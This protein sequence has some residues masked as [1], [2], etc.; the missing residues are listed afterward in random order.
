M[1]NASLLR[2]ILD[3]QLE[4]VC[5]FEKDGTILFVNNAYANTLGASAAELTGGNLWQYISEADRAHVESQVRL[6][7]PDHPT[8][9]IENRFETAA[10]TR[11]ILWRNHAIQFDAA[12]CWTV[13]QATGVDITER[14]QLEAQRNLLIDELDHRVRNT[15]M[16]VQGMAH[17]SFRGSDMPREA[18]GAFN[19]RLQ[20]LAQAHALLSAAHG[21]VTEL[22]DLVRQGLTI[23]DGDPRVTAAGPALALPPNCTVAL[24]M[25]LHELATNAIKYGALSA[26]AGTVE[27]A[28][29]QPQSDGAPRVELEWRERGVGGVVP[30]RTSGFG[31][32]LIAETITG[33]LN[34]T[35]DMEF[36]P[37]GLTCRMTFPVLPAKVPECLLVSA[38]MQ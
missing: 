35:V 25:V 28:W 15:L 19:A 1:Y 20:A 14:K 18:L 24:V 32:R 37:D 16:V 27:I 38:E 30:P 17:Q 9:N 26:H 11:W 10:G 8:L 21:P 22:A 4:M 29:G 5:R 2:E 13:A 31:T 3:A 33:Q 12:G 36:A 6:L 7:T 23:C 34:G